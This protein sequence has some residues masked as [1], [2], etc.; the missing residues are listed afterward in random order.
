M[1]TVVSLS[2]NGPDVAKRRPECALCIRR[3]ECLFGAMTSGDAAPLNV[4]RVIYHAGDRLFEQ[5][6]SAKKVMFV[7]TGTAKTQMTDANGDLQVVG[8]PSAGDV[9]GVLPG[10]AGRHACTAIALDTVAVCEVDREELLNALSHSPRNMAEVLSRCA[11][12]SENQAKHLL[13]LGQKT[14]E[15]RMAAFVLD[16]SSRMRNAGLASEQVDLPMSRADLGSYLALAVETVSRLL[17]RLQ[18]AGYLSVQRHGVGILNR[19][20]LDAVVNPVGDMDQRG[21]A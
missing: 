1:S 9:L 20:G 17:T 14:A 18:D 10:S 15:Q 13:L 5:G 7:G 11:A 16:R 12:E 4:T 2:N 3:N 21:A 8:F 19:Q 6:E